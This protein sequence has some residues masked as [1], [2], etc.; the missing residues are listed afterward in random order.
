MFLADG[1]FVNEELIRRGYSR[2][3]TRFPTR[4]ADE[5]RRLEAEARG[6][7]RGLWGEPEAG[8]EPDGGWIIGN[9]RSGIYHVPGQE[10]YEDVAPRN[11]ALFRSG[12]EA[13]AAGYRRARR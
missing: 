10:H 13:R 5:F 7:R 1:T 11:R 4:Y 6:A 12:A 9:R 8:N 3:L 2:A